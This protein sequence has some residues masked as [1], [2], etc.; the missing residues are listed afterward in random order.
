MRPD[1]VKCVQHTHADKKNQ[2]WCGRSTDQFEWTF[3]NLDHAAYNAL[4]GGR[5]VLCDNCR[6]AAIAALSTT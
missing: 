5:L 4:Q 1:Y 6:A 2:T 3:V